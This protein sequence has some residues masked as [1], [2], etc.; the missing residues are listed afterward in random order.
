MGVLTT[1][2]L[3]LG[4]YIRAPGLLEARTYACHR[5]PYEMTTKLYTRGF[6]DPYS[7]ATKL[8]IR[9]AGHGYAKPA[10]NGPDIG[11]HP[12]ICIYIYIPTSI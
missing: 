3:L 9:S 6:R 10:S 12:Y 7:W 5:D 11:Q 1:R 2:V 4:V 8:C